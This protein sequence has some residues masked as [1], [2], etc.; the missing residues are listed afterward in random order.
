MSNF[1]SVHPCDKTNKAGCEQL[2]KK[3]GDEAV[4]K[5]KPGFKL[6]KNRKNCTKV[7]PCDHRSGGCE[8]ICQKHGEKAICKC[9]PGFVLEED[10]LNCK[11]GND[12]I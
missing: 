8:Q 9:K 4:C 3:K 1:L 10:G 12:Y 7:H 6:A 2:C 11:K 5:C